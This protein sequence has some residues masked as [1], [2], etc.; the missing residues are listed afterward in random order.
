MAALY[1]IGYCARNIIGIEVNIKSPV[2]ILLT[3]SGPQTFRPEDGPRYVPAEIAIIVCWGAC[4]LILLA[5]LWWYNKENRRKA[6][7]RSQ[8]G[9]QRLENQEEVV[10]INFFTLL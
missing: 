4:L 2:H 9:C 3:P 1:L 5:I 6:H 8:P 10:M 7:I